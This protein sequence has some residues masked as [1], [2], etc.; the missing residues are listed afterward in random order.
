MYKRLS[1]A[2]L[3]LLSVLVV[4]IVSPV[5]SETNEVKIIFRESAGQ[6]YTTALYKTV[7]GDLKKI[8]VEVSK[9]NASASLPP[10]ENL[11]Q[12]DVLVIPNPGTD[13]QENEL[14][15]IKQYLDSGGNLIIMG[16]IQYDDRHYGKPDYLN[17]LLDYI[18]ISNKVSFWG[19]ND[20]GD[21]IKDNVNNLGRSWQVL[22][23][24]K[25][26]K[27]HIISVGI[28]KVAVNSPSLVVS[29]P[30]IIVATSPSTSYAEDTQGNIHASGEIPWLV[31]IETEGGKVVIC[32][33]SK[34]FSDALIYG[35]GQS[36][37]SYGDNERLFF[38]IIWWLT[39]VR[40]RA[41]LVAKVFIPILDIFG[42][43]AGIVAA[44]VYK[45]R[46]RDI[47]IFSV[48]G[49]IIFA[50][51]AV[52]Q[53]I[54][55]GETV[56]GVSWPGWGYVSAGISGEIVVEAWQVAGMRYFL[57]GIIIVL[58]GAFIYWLV[59]KLDEYLKLGIRERL[60]RRAS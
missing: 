45:L 21:E 44:H 51:I 36:Y 54:L 13:F 18:G 7:I 6:Y 17:N 32:G 39:G 43:I 26:F 38:N 49:G 35:T 50:L 41:P 56:I 23:T 34:I 29:D 37:I 42:I 28:T 14:A 10:L 59:M 12:Y 30:D 3:F 22:V 4:F 8:G 16:D 20:N 31:A 47:L 55:F 25:Q 58:V 19:T 1:L 15:L 57:A 24:S 2:Y 11:S 5:H 53:V 33:G 48:I 46:S 52:L 27:P 9:Y 60:E 40:V